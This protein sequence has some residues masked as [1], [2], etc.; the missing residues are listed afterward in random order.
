MR[1]CAH[2]FVVLLCDLWRTGPGCSSTP[3]SQGLSWIV[4]VKCDRLNSGVVEVGRSL[5]PENIKVG[6]CIC[7]AQSQ[8]AS[9]NMSES[10][11]TGR[12]KARFLSRGPPSREPA[13]TESRAV[14]GWPSNPW[15]RRHLELSEPSSR[16]QD[17]AQAV[18]QGRREVEGSILFRRC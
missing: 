3:Y 17:G 9:L 6:S 16:K 13:S 11:G 1:W 14:L 8:D 7:F 4:H 18:W 15:K 10:S 2:L 5:Q 12:A